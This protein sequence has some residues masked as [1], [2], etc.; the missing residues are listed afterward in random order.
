MLRFTIPV[1]AGNDAV[2][3]GSLGKVMETL[4]ELLKPEA[5]YFLPDGGERSGMI[6]FDMKD[7]SDIPVIAEPLFMELGAAVEF[8]PVMNG[9]DLKK[10]LGRV[11]SGG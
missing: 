9:D 8:V 5:A 1:E 3:N 4:M 7:S 10:G 2:K 11:M 6:F